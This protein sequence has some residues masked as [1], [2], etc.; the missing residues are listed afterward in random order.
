MMASAVQSQSPI[1]GQISRPFLDFRFLISAGLIA[2]GITVAV[3]ALAT[4]SGVSANDL[5]LMTVYP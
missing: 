4:S 3:Y 1:L 2:T 5:A